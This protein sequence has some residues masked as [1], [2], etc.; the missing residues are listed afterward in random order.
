MSQVLVREESKES[1]CRERLEECL[2][3]CMG[4]ECNKCHDDFEKCID[5]ARKEG[6]D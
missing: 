4:D 1:L 5:N 2:L 3:L 6:E